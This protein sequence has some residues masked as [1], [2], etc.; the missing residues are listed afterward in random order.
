MGRTFYRTAPGGSPAPSAAWGGSRP[1]GG[2][3]PPGAALLDRTAS[4]LNTTIRSNQYQ[5]DT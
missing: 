4:P 1:R 3:Q 2:P 5:R